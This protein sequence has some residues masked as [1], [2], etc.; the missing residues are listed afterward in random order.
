[1][2][3]LT[4]AFNRGE[5]VLDA[6]RR[7][8]AW[9]FDTFEDIKVS[10]SGGAD[11]SATA[12]L[13]LQEAQRR[14]RKVGLFFLDEEVMYQSCIDQ[15][16]YLIEE[17]APDCVIPLWLQ[18][19]FNL[20]NATSYSESHLIAWEPGQHQKWMRPKKSYAMK[21]HPW[22]RSKEIILDRRIGLDFYAMIANFEACYNGNA[23]VVGLRG[24]E[25]PNRWRTV[26]KNPAHING[27]DI[28]WGTQKGNNFALY[29]L[30]DWL[31]S[32]VWKY[33]YERKLR[34]S[35]VY[36]H[37]FRKGM[38]LSEIRTSSLIHERSHKSLVELPEF[39]PKTYNKL[40]KRIK[41]ISFAQ[42]TGK[43]AKMFKAQKLPQQFK[44]WRSYRDFLLTTYPEPD[45][46]A[47][48]EKRF[49]GHLNNEYVARQQVRQLVLCDIENNVA[50][51]N[52]ED[53]RKEWV[54]Y[55]MEVL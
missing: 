55:Y 54:K 53:P 25:S 11:S 29:P 3:R 36:D 27:Q 7:R 39:E 10:I 30:Y 18:A 22:D 21:F 44:S 13:M 8:I 15:I 40:L 43:A 9:I 48:F 31:Q 33:T 1:M 34:Y 35:K 5:N 23:F 50:V 12:D 6:A 45:K 51:I 16:E 17:H 4:Q 28:Y 46:K 37:M 2:S 49:A 19:E 32:D 26:S 42:E 20:T 41:G 24:T 14:G 52:R 47:I 38:H